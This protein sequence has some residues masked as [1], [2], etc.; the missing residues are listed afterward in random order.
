LDPPLIKSCDVTGDDYEFVTGGKQRPCG[1]CHKR[2]L[3]EPAL[4]G[5]EQGEVAAPKDEDQTTGAKVQQ[6]RDQVSGHMIQEGL[7]SILW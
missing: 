6:A 1:A 4:V 3:E 2:T 7:P 5:S